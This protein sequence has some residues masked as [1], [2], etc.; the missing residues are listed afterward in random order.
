MNYFTNQVALVTGAGSGIGRQLSLCLAREG[1]F[2]GGVDLNADPL[3]ALAA[4]LPGGRFAWAVGDVTKRDLLRDAVN[5]ITKQLGPVDLLIANAG[6][7]FENS[8]LSFKAEEFEQHI[9]V[10][11]IGVANSIETVLAGMIERKKGH[12]VGISSLASYRGVPKLLGYC[13]SKSGVN[14]LLEG[15]RAELIPYNIAVTTICPGW[16]R[17]PLAAK[18]ELPAN[19]F[20]ELSD[21]AER[22]LGAIRDRRPFFAF[23]SWG[24]R[25]VRLLKWLPAAWSD[26]LTLKSVPKMANKATSE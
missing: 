14:A 19:M 24:V 17:T 15:L 25:R 2:V 1:A 16:I 20:L 10:N 9:R 8:A 4:E 6:I 5:K 11:L 7:G 12:L 13:A 3:S 26:W 21:A 23:P 18:V 22:I